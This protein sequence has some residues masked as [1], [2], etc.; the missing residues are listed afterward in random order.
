MGFSGQSAILSTI[1]PIGRSLR[2][3]ELILKV[4]NA[5]EPWLYD[6]AVMAKTWEPVPVPKKV[7]IGVIYW[8]EVVMPHPPICKAMKAAVE[9]LKAAGHE[10]RFVP[11]IGEVY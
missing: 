2:D 3:L 10:G 4:W 6:P 1:G 9:K 8:D 11:R 5:F 7:T